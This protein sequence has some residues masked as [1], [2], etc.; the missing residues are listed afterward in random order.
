MNRVAAG[1][2]STPYVPI[3]ATRSPE[4]HGLRSSMA[5]ADTEGAKTG[6]GQAAVEAIEFGWSNLCQ[7]EVAEV[8]LD[9]VG[10]R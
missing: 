5:L 6:L 10:D 1:Q 2:V 4:C 8:G 7:G 3:W 9:V